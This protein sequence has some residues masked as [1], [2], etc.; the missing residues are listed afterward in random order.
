MTLLC[1]YDFHDNLSQA[2]RGLLGIVDSVS[3]M[4]FL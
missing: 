1:E 3:I 2:R 4:G